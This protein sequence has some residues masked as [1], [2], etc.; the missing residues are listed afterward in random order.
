MN[1]RTLGKLGVWSAASLLGANVFAIA[2][3]SLPTS[4]YWLS[5]RAMFIVLF[6]FILIPL[7]GIACLLSL[8]QKRW[9]GIL[10]ALLAAVAL[11]IAGA[12]G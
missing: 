7:A 6:S 4:P 10:L 8:G 5:R 1:R 9:I 11:A 3:R 2:V 12:C